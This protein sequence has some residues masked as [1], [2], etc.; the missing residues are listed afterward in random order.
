MCHLEIDPKNQEEVVKA[1]HEAA[2]SVSECRKKD[3]E[4]AVGEILTNSL[5]HAIN[6]DDRIVIDTNREEVVIRSR[7]L[8]SHH[9]EVKE[10][11][12][13]PHGQIEDLNDPYL[14]DENDM[15]PGIGRGFFI[16]KSV[17]DDVVAEPGSIKMTFA[18]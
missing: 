10:A 2:E 12:G 17:A 11:I 3:V 6:E 14:H 18:A 16:V 1:R 13:S 15:N 5:E 7:S 8:F 4:L 9:S